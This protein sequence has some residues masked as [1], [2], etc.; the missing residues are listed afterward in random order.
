MTDGNASLFS[1]A[2]YF[3]L[4]SLLAVG[5]ANATIPEMHRIAVDAQRWMTDRQFVELFA[6]SQI[7]PGPNILIVS[8]IGFQTAGLPGALVATLAMCGPSSLL[9]YYVSRYWDRARQASWR[10]VVMTALVPISIG[11]VGASAYLLA[12]TIDRTW[13][14]GLITAATAV[15]GFRARFN[16]LWMLLGGAVLGLAGLV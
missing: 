10:V 6:I 15:I 8:L 5:G 2:A 16:P 3:A 13:Q 7:A 4:L 14:T 1:L 12:V 11:L 9:C